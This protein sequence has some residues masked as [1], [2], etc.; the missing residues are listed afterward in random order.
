MKYTEIEN[1]FSVARMSRYLTAC[2]GNTK[3]AMTLYRFNL[4]LSQEF[5]TLV[6]CFE[7]SLRNTINDKCLQDLGNDWLRNGAAA[8][9]VGF[10]I[11]GIVD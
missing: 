5:F 9:T 10:L 7:I 3:K 11:T 4:R 1:I 2:Q 6:S 8:G